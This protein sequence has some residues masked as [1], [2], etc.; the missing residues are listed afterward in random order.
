MKYLYDID[1][2]TV[3]VEVEADTDEEADAA[4]YDKLDSGFMAEKIGAATWVVSKSDD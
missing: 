3:T 2:G 4:V 1:I